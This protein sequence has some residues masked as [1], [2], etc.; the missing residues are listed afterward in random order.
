M[1]SVEIATESELDRVLN[2]SASTLAFRGQSN[3]SWLVQ[4]SLERAAGRNFGERTE[5]MLQLYEADI[6]DWFIGEC[7]RYELGAIYPQGK[8]PDV[9]NTFE[10]LSLLQHHGY[11]TR[12]IDFTDDIWVAMYF[13]LRDSQPT[14]PFA[15]YVLEMI[16]DDESGNK[17]PKDSTG[18]IYRASDGCPNINELLGLTIQ[19]RNFRSHYGATSLSLEWHRP[20]QNYGWDTPAIHNERCKRQKGRFLYQLYP[21]GQVESAAALTKYTI[22][23]HLSSACV[24]RSQAK[25][26]SYS[27]RFLFPSFEGLGCCRTKRM[28]R[29][30]R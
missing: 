23:P 20:K 6:I 7:G 11:P 12:L 24:R 17:L 8:L 21:D 14:V 18:S 25:G 4:S 19:F 26:E 16:P 10:W 5:S 27:Q 29:T 28:H 3:A 13:V 2:D 1:N 22:S 30:R 9:T 15:I